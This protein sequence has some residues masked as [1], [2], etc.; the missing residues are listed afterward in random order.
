LNGI[1]Q[2]IYLSGRRRCRNLFLK[3]T[4]GYAAPTEAPRAGTQQG[5]GSHQARKHRFSCAAADDLAM[6]VSYT[7]IAD[8]GLTPFS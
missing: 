8:S 1:N 5:S 4:C 2:A 6:T 3:Q 7:K